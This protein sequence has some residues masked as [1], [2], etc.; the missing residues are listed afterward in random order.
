MSALD[1]QNQ[2]HQG[3]KPNLNALLAEPDDSSDANK[4]NVFFKLGESLGVGSAL[5]SSAAGVKKFG[6]FTAKR[7]DKMMISNFKVVLKMIGAKLNAQLHDDP[8]PVALHAWIN[9]LFASFWPELQ[10]GEHAHRF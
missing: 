7:V 5:E 9:R 2:D 1:S 4:P 6:D 8:M 10:K 3:R